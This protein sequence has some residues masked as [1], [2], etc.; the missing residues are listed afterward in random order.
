M[1]PVPLLLLQALALGC[2]SPAEPAADLGLPS[3]AASQ[4][5][6]QTIAEAYPP[7]PG[8]HRVPADAFGAWLGQRLLAE[9]ER[10]VRTWDGRVVAQDARVIELPLV[11]G[12]LQQCADTAIRLRAE[13]LR[14][15][16]LPVSFHAT[17][18]DPVPWARWVQ[19]E[20]PRAV[21]RGL[22]WSGGG[23]AGDDAESWSR[24]LA[25]VFTWAGTASLERHDTVPADAP[26]AGD[27]VVQGGF[28]GH[29][30]ILL[31]VAV[32]P[33]D[34]TW[35]L[36]GEGFMPAQDAH[37]QHGPHRGWWRWDP[38]AGLALPYWPLPASALRRW[39]G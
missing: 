18:G 15:Q 28:P 23:R 12:D 8:A 6:P 26:R 20:R 16:G 30:V 13:F 14:E 29:A 4:A 36:V 5:G 31:D 21:G 39:K 35:V 1:S 9:P 37:V 2:P 32:Q 22:Q 3:P 7:P 19:G 38:E 25:A 17:S 10:P 27:L 34:T 24:Y 33:D 11:P